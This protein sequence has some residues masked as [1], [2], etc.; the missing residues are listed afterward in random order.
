MR[1]PLGTS[2]RSLFS[3]LVSFSFLALT[4][5]KMDTEVSGG[6]AHVDTGSSGAHGPSREYYQSMMVVLAAARDLF[7]KQSN[8][9]GLELLSEYEK[10]LLSIKHRYE[11]MSG[12]FGGLAKELGEKK[13]HIKDH[14]EVTE[15]LTEC[16]NA[17][18][19]LM[20][21]FQDLVFS[22]RAPL[23]ESVDPVRGRTRKP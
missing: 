17:I 2:I 7:T 9:E 16:I 3:F 13:S 5:R 18:Q 23:R 19:G 4:F 6:S 21:K 22:L 14:K 15:Y 10:I 11:R 1:L 8:K 12:Y 20:T